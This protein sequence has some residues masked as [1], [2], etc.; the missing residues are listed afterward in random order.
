MIFAAFKR[1]V[2][3]TIKSTSGQA[4][5]CNLKTTLSPQSPPHPVFIIMMMMILMRI[6]APII[7]NSTEL[8]ESYFEIK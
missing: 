2:L 3:H 5:F 1:V 8:E 6:F 4:R 7:F